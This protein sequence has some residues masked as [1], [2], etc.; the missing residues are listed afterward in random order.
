MDTDASMP[1]SQDPAEVLAKQKLEKKEKHLSSC[2][3]QCKEFTLLMFSVDGVYGTEARAASQ[4]W[5][6]SSHNNGHDPMELCVAMAGLIYYW[7]WYE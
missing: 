6:S 3:V 4:C 1:Y 7:L 5:L 2:L